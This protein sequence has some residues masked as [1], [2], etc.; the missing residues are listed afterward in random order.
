[1]NGSDEQVCRATCRPQRGW[2]ADRRITCLAVGAACVVYLAGCRTQPTRSYGIKGLEVTDFGGHLDLIARHRDRELKSKTTSSETRSKETIFEESLSLQAKGNVLHPNLFEFGLGAAF[3]LVQEDFQDIVDGRERDISQ[4]GDLFEF[5]VDLRAFKKRAWPVSVF[6]HRRRG[7]VPRPFL[8]SLE[9][10]TT[11]YGLTWQYVSK[12]TPMSLH[13][14]HTDAKLSPLFIGTGTDEEGRQRNTELRF[15]AGYHFSD[16]HT[17][18]LL[19]EHDSVDEEPFEVDYDAD[20]VTLTHRLAF[21]GRQQHRL[22][23]EFNYLN[24]RGTI[25]IERTRWREDLRLKHT[26][27]LQSRFWLEAL[28]RTRASRLRS[29]PRVKERSVHISGTL[30][31]QL[32]E[33]Q[34]SRLQLFVRRQEFEPD[35]DITRW[36]GQTTINYRRTNPWGVLYAD[37]GFRFERNDHEGSTQTNE[38]VDE[39]RTFRDPE[40][41]TLG[42][43]NV[44]TGSITVRA[45]DRVTSYYRGWDFS[46]QTVGNLIE[47]R[48]TPGGRI[49]DGET[50]LINYLFEFG[51]TFELDTLSHNFGVR[52]AFDLG[53]TPYYRFEWQDQSLSPASAAGALA[54]DITAHV[55]GLEY[56]KASLRLSAEYEDRESTINPFISTRFRASYIHRFKSGAET[57]FHARWTDTS[58]GSPH[59]RDIKL[60]TLEGRHRHPITPN[61]TVEGSVLYRDGEDSVSRDTQGVD[62]SLSLEWSVRET[63]VRMSF[64]HSEFEDEF[65]RNDSSAVFVHLRRGI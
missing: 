60:L 58:H 53:L 62:V 49:A 37:Y 59:E 12:K 29:I 21:G 5:D 50:V 26:D 46:V 31:H 19:Y 4:N 56:Q 54:E 24:Q 55:V 23:S 65:T 39:L 32:F 27:T 35:L 6:A 42:N 22:R 15:E 36:G 1:M 52:Q 11:S 17:L 61:L 48:R 45:E 34:T 13:F 25:D 2:C 18:S 10:T 40:P 28:D 33:S 38:I 8:P 47:I 64:E 43:R 57:A 9:T 3:G 20:E 7:L 44:I 16:H 14:S 41:I 30:R 63:K 51:G